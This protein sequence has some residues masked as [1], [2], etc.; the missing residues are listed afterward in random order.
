MG[1]NKDEDLQH[2]DLLIREYEDGDEVKILEGFNRVFAAV[3]PSFVPR[4]MEEWMWRFRENPDGQ[5]MRLAFTPE[6]NLAGSFAGMCQKMRLNGEDARFLQ[7]V[8]NFT[9]PSFRKSLRRDSL[10]A[11]LVNA[12]WKFIRG[13]APPKYAV[14]WGLPVVAAWRVG[15]KMIGYKLVRT[16]LELFAQLGDVRQGPTEGIEVEEVTSFPEET[17][18]LFERAAEPHAAIAVRDKEHC[19]WRFFRKPGHN[20]RVAV[21]RR[22]QELLGY[23]VFAKGAF[24]GRED[25]GL[26]VDWLVPPTA[27]G[28]SNAL[29][30]WLCDV[31]SE[32]GAERLVAFF[33]ETMPEFMAFQLAGFRAG[34]T[35]YFPICK[36]HSRNHDPLWLYK[37]WFYTFA[38][39]DL[40]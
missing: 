23:T 2:G 34:P 12:N 27:L 36:H 37:N 29:R 8:D 31:A 39:T 4:T 25:Q 26:I 19:D 15:G 38:D 33:P 17:D 18:A 11:T 32:T 28:A 24:D 10:L 3:N 1:R 16:Q 20:Y 40:V 9:D 5:S 14:A 35:S 6:G 22:G 7:G 21:A 13:D 30:A